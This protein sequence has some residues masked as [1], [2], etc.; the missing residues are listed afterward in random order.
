M[1]TLEIQGT[2]IKIGETQQKSQT[3]RVRQFVLQTE[4]QYPQK[5]AIQFV[6][7]NTTKLD[8]YQLGD[9]ATVGVNIRGT[10]YADRSTGEMKYFVNL[11]AWRIAKVQP[12]HTSH[13]QGPPAYDPTQAQI[14]EPTGSDLP[15]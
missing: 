11:S 2:I 8:D 12:T 7:D 3:F 4:G 6:N 13:L 1:P 10:E 9:Q 5:L 15:F 14:D